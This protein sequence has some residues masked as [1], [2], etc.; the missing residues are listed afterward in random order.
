ML[1]A[2]LIIAGDTMQ[3]KQ[4]ARSASR[5]AGIVLKQIRSLPILVVGVVNAILATS[6]S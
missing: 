6:Y 4:S 2:E 5:D 3:R 1:A